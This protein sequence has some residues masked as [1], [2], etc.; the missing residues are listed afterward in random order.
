MR[1]CL[2]TAGVAP[3]RWRLQPWRYLLE[4][5]RLL[6]Q[7]GHSVI[8]I[9]NCEVGRPDDDEVEGVPVQRI[10]DVRPLWRTPNPA[11]EQVIVR[12][13]PKMLIWHVGLTSF[14]HFNITGRFVA[15][16]IG[17]F[18][19]PVYHLADVLRPGLPH[20][21]QESELSALHALGLLVPTWVIRR[22]LRDTRLRRLV[23]LSDMTRQALIQ[24]GVAPGLVTTISPGLDT[25]WL[26]PV[27]SDEIGAVR[28][29]LGLSTNDVLVT[30][31]GAPMRLRGLDILV[32]AF[33]Q[34][35][36]ATPN[37]KL[38]ILSRRRPY[39]PANG[40]ERIRDLVSHLE[41]DQVVTLVSGF[42]DRQLVKRY[43][44]A[45]DMMALP[46]ELVPSDMPLSVL[47][48]LALGKPVIATRTACL[49]EMIP[50]DGGLL[51]TPA[52]AKSL[53]EALNQLAADS[54]QRVDMAEHA[55]QFAVR[56]GSWEDRSVQWERLLQTP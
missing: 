6:R 4:T 38:L 28:Q 30:Y 54:T 18:T 8:I 49:P 2:I 25:E 13:Q 36:Q 40:E 23:T 55:R 44:A 20:L 48:A 39:E 9:S 29:G 22:Q 34:A 56:W 5:A 51:V 15:P 7:M 24:R 26:E 32:K 1:L 53:A 45:S 47:E 21:L 37:L 17:I 27:P 50:P 43:L 42:L 33:A 12:H 10:P 11:L 3:S 14:L 52:D 16:S 31:A 41:L 19:S 35:R 46:F